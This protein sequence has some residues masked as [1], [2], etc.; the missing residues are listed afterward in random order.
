MFYEFE[1]LNPKAC[2][3]YL[4]GMKGSKN[5]AI[6]DPVIDHLQD[7][8]DMLKNQEY[9]LKYI[10]D[11]HTHADH[12]SGS[13][14]L[15]D[16]TDADI[17]MHELAPSK[18]T[19]IRVNEGDVLNLEEIPMKFLHT[20]GHTRD[21]ISLILP[22]RI[23]TG[24][25]LFLDD[26][27]AGRDDLP[28]GNPADHWESLQKLLGLSEEILI[29]PA[30]DYRERKISSLK[31]QKTSNPHLKPRSKDEFIDYINDLKLGPADWM[32]DVLKANYHCARDPNAAWIPV[33]SPACEI[34][35]TIDQNINEQQVDFINS[36][37]LKE[38]IA[39]E[40]DILLID[41]REP[42]EFRGPLGSIP[43]SKNFPLMKLMN[44]LDQMKDY[45][46]KPFYIICRSGG[47]A[48]TMA[49]VFKQAGYKDPI[50]L[51]GGMIGW[52]MV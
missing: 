4:F 36:F 29:C 22:G 35:G 23:L 8:V 13:S 12:I 50:V 31:K 15:K 47:R 10:I 49:K 39:K 25:A 52:Q 43:N 37:N 3:T 32:K 17:I 33:D 42:D 16:V 41:V 6:V 19:S 51:E 11:T 18:C 7:Y 20:P 26:G 24:D 30:H 44:N 38:K 21:S 48:S 28:G 46:N 1:Q 45:K 27:G 2:K 34:Q 9:Q 14:A 5:V 40:S